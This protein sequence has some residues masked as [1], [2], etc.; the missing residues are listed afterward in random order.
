M[1]GHATGA[2]KPR[3][4]IRT[5]TVGV[6]P[7]R[8]GNGTLEI[9]TCIVG[10]ATTCIERFANGIDA[11]TN[12]V[13][14]ALDLRVKAGPRAADLFRHRFAERI[15]DILDLA[16][17]TARFAPQPLAGLF[18]TGG[19]EEQ[20]RTSAEC[21]AEQQHADTVLAVTFNDYHA[22]IVVLILSTHTPPRPPC[23]PEL[24]E[25]LRFC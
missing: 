1:F 9:L 10:G 8:V 12:G 20:R 7:L 2:C 25:S 17:C 11:R 13:A 6:R 5:T 18:A 14:C 15:G 4:A 16:S 22:L 3:L 23:G 24:R 21:E 19:G